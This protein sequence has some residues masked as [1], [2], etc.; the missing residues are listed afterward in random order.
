MAFRIGWFFWPLCPELVWGYKLMEVKGDGRDGDRGD[1]L[2]V[3]LGKE[4]KGKSS[5]IMEGIGYKLG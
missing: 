2:G 3:D 1:R 5:S 4:T